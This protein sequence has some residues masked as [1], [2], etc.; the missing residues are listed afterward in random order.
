MVLVMLE[1]DEHFR[2]RLGLQPSLSEAEKE[3]II[4]AAISLF[5]I[6]IWS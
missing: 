1:G 4:G 3:S 5:L 6:R 2:C